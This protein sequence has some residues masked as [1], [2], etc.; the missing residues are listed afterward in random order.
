MCL[1]K[2]KIICVSIE[3]VHTVFSFIGTADGKEKADFLKEI[4][5][6]IKVSET[7]SELKKFVVNTLGCC[8]LYEPIL[9]V[10]EFVAYGDLLRYL[11]AEKKKMVK[12][13]ITGNQK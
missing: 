10:V 9:L 6:M 2:K 3:Q 7:D 5:T 1:N 13:R 11:R 4:D 12:V 8:R